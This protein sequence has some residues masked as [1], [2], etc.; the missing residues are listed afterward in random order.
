MHHNLIDFPKVLSLQ[1][2]TTLIDFAK[3]KERLTIFRALVEKKL[4]PDNLSV[5]EVST[6]LNYTNQSWSRLTAIRVLVKNKLIPNNLSVDEV[7]SI[8]GSLVD[9]DRED[10]D[11]NWREYAIRTL[12]NAKNPIIK[13]PIDA[14]DLTKLLKGVKRQDKV[15][16]YLM[17][18]CLTQ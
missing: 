18:T 16:E 3:D 10:G 11:R 2:I 4:I 9:H 17:L 13:T 12:T 15:M 14:E 8:A 7:T 6:L 5:N 1:N